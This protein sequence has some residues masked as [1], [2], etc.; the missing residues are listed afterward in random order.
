MK[1]AIIGFIFIVSIFF[2]ECSFFKV[3]A[4]INTGEYLVGDVNSDC[5]VNIS[6]VNYLLYNL[7]FD[8]D[9]YPVNQN[10]DYNG[11]NLKNVK[12]VTYLLYHIMFGD[13]YPLYDEYANYE[14]SKIIIEQ[15]P[16]K[17]TQY[18]EDELDLTGLVVRV[19]YINNSSKVIEDFEISYDEL[20]LGNNKITINYQEF[21]TSFNIEVVKKD[22]ITLIDHLDYFNQTTKKIDFND[23]VKVYDDVEKGVSR[24]TNMFI[25]YDEAHFV[26]T[27]IYGYEAAVDQYGRIV[28]INTNVSLPNGGMVLSAHGTRVNEIKDLE[29]GDFV[30]YYNNRV[31]IYKDKE[32]SLKN[33]VF[34]K[35]YDVLDYYQ[36]ID[37]IYI[38]NDG[39]NKLNELIPHLDS[40]YNRYD[41]D[42]EKIL[43]A[44]FDNIEDEDIYDHIHQYSYVDKNY[45]EYIVPN[46]D[47][48]Y[49]LLTTYEKKL[50]IG[51]FRN[52]DTLVYYDAEHYR[53][54]NPYGYEVS[55]DKN[56]IVVDKNTLVDLAPDGF[57][58]SGHT[59]TADF[60]YLNVEINDK[61]EIVDGKVYIYRDNIRSYCNKYVN[62]R[63]E[64]VNEINTELE[65]NIPHDYEYLNEI[66][67]LIDLELDKINKENLSLF[68]Y[69]KIMQSI[70]KLEEYVAVAYGQLLEYEAGQTRGIWYYPFNKIDIYDDTSLEG[71]RDTLTTFKKMGINE[72]IIHTF[73]KGYCLFDNSVFL[74][75][76]VLDN[77]DYGEY[78]KDYLKC[79]IEEA[80]KLDISVSAFTQTFL[81]NIDTMKNPSDDYYQINYQGEKSMGQVY[82]YDICSDEV[83]EFLL[84]WYKELVTKYDFDKVEYDIIRYPNSTLYKYLD[85]EEIPN[86]VTITDHG[87]TEYSMNKFMK[88]YG[89]SGDLKELIKTSLDVRTKWLSF[90]EQELVNFITECSNEMRK[91]NPNLLITAAVFNMYEKAK[92]GYLQD[93]KKWLELGIVDEIEIMMYTVSNYNLNEMIEDASYLIENYQVKL[94]LSPR[95]DGGDMITDLQ[96]MLEGTRRDGFVLFSSTLYYG[97]ILENILASSYHSNFVSH[98]S[99]PDEIMLAKTNDCIDMIK[100][101]YGP[102]NN[103]SYDSLIEAL[104]TGENVEE[105]L[106][107]ITDELM[108]EYLRSK[109]A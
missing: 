105:E 21:S 28:E 46:E 24:K 43:L 90:K 18:I 1:K 74:T 44:S 84:T 95:L 71:I 32:I 19:V 97:D 75:S 83:Q 8:N 35:F 38:Y 2:I 39:I 31:Y 62:L 101:Y 73:Y 63:N 53:Q 67:K 98:I 108:E 89:L 9:D 27:N 86:N 15:A 7:M 5:V 88:Q 80:H 92:S 93:Y 22:K 78:G 107:L 10:T 104:K 70:S 52:S 85:V 25:V 33:E 4:S 69:I 66:I 100:G 16:I 81:E 54:R 57:I 23:Y 58:L 91:I 45:D 87:Y 60:L 103:C 47:S 42:L 68:K 36:T 11:D 106:Q 59:S 50:Y 6:D 41:P 51:G 77:Y 49:E 3:E 20:K 37:D 40:Y 17:T 64:L 26:K 72:V 76:S 56:G 82:Y 102:K 29:I 94:G 34:V 109:L 99:S 48:V 30:L 14:I 61:I 96:Q 55:V 13:E 12:D 65:K 79:F